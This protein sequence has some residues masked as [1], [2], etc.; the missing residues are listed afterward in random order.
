MT[1]VSN[2][3]LLAKIAGKIGRRPRPP[4]LAEFAEHEVADMVAVGEIPGAVWVAW[5]QMGEA[6]IG[7][8]SSITFARG[9]LRVQFED[10]AAHHAAFR[11]LRKGGPGFLEARRVSKGAVKRIWT[12]L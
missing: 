11:A 3:R 2:E 9:V 6:W 10:A 4:L 8:V 7:H 5:E 1:R 12:T